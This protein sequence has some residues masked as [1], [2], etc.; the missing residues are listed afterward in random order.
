MAAYIL[1]PNS[2]VKLNGVDVSSSAKAAA[3]SYARVV[4]PEARSG[5]SHTTHY[6]GRE[7]SG[8]TLTLIHDDT[9]QDVLDTLWGLDDFRVFLH[10]NSAL[11]SRFS[12]KMR[13]ER[14][15]PAAVPIGSLATTVVQFVSV[16]RMHRGLLLLNDFQEGSG[17]VLTDL[18]GNGF[19][20]ELGTAPGGDTNDP[21]WI[22]SPTRLSFI[23]DDILI[24]PADTDFETPEV[25][26][27]V[28]VKLDA[29]SDSGVHV[30]LGKELCWELRQTTA[31]YNWTVPGIVNL[32]GQAVPDTNWHI[33]A[34]VAEVVGSDVKLSIYLDG[35]LDIASSAAGSVVQS[36][37]DI[38][39]G[40]I[41]PTP[42]SFLD[43]DIVRG[44]VFNRALQARE[45]NSY[46]YDWREQLAELGVTLP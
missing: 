46:Y 15:S 8:I 44:A 14:V 42:I 12:A 37:K 35:V 31:D 29:T 17:Q 41:G 13:L 36:A 26:V 18:S 28:A 3:V 6:V 34:A 10:P 9:V 43:G 40:A 30:I 20:G 23:T 38:S 7:T 19:A 25:T 45:I 33:L 24:V 21:A 11:R 39:Y 2:V 27:M 1:G 4:V 22:S 32:V 5:T 16:G